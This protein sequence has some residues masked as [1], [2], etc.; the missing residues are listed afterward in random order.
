M[1]AT[2]SIFVQLVFQ[3]C[4]N[5]AEMIRKTNVPKSPKMQILKMLREL[6]NPTMLRNAKMIRNPTMLR[7]LIITSIGHSAVTNSPLGKLD[8]YSLYNNFKSYR[9]IFSP[10]ENIA[11]VQELFLFLRQITYLRLRKILFH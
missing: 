2:M 5:A 1:L 10:V 3:M 6:R 11:Y 7:L 9:N 4:S 8:L